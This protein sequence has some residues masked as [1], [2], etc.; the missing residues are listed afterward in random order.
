LDEQELILLGAIGWQL[1]VAIEN[2]RLWEELKKRDAVRSQLL[3]QAITAQEDE[4]RRIARELHDQTG[5][6]L[7]SLLVRLRLLDAEADYVGGV[8]ISSAHLQELKAIVAD[9]LDGV[10]E[11]AIELRPSVLDDLGLVP[12]LQRMC[13][14]ATIGMSLKSTFRRWD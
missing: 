12:A 14:P 10:H 13:A 1:G 5:Q 3:E 7:T 11:L 2:A 9:T 4:R 6:A 8:L